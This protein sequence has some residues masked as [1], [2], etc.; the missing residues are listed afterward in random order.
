MARMC[1]AMW[2]Q[3]PDVSGNR[4]LLMLFIGLIAVAIAGMA[5]VL[6]AFSLKA[7]KAIKELT[8]SAEEVKTKLLPLLDEVTAFSRSGRELLQ[9]SAP[10]ITLI[11]DNLVKTSET[12]ADTSQVARAAVQKIDSTL[13]DANQRAQRQVARVDGMVS[14][15]LTTTAEV[16]ETINHG[17]RVPAQKIA[18]MANQAR[19][20]A[21]GLFARIKSMAAASPFASRKAGP[22]AGETRL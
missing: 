1:F 20:M 17:I 14:A 13:T 19:F 22:Q 8:T 4:H 12:L 16:V 3:Q 11:A 15:A 2:I 9:E 10:K 7:L 5:I 21:E 18:V 6:I